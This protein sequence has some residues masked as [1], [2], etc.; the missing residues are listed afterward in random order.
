MDRVFLPARANPILR[1]PG[2]SAHEVIQPDGPGDGVRLVDH[3]DRVDLRPTR[4]LRQFLE[5]PFGESGRLDIGREL[6]FPIDHRRR[7]L[8]AGVH[9]ERRQIDRRLAVEL[10]LFGHTLHGRAGEGFELLKEVEI[11]LQHFRFLLDPLRLQRQLLDFL[12]L[13]ADRRACVFLH[14]SGAISG[15]K[16]AEAVGSFGIHGIGRRFRGKRSD[17]QFDQPFAFRH[18]DLARDQGVSLIDRHRDDFAAGRLRRRR[19][20]GFLHRLLGDRFPFRR[21]VAA[22]RD[23]RE[24]Q[25]PPNQPFPGGHRLRLRKFDSRRESHFAPRFPRRGS[26]LLLRRSNLPFSSIHLRKPAEMHSAPIRISP[27]VSHRSTHWKSVGIINFTAKTKELR[28][29]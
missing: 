24:K 28:H 1:P 21:F 8:G 16:D 10:S 11:L 26:T 15:A 27:I 19:L 5:L 14:R 13:D 23:A 2:R 25:N 18:I 9:H 12:F 7:L 20:F 17:D 4:S 22:T 3:D 29:D 6:L